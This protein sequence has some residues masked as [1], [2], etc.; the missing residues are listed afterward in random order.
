MK[1]SVGIIAL[2]VMLSASAQA[3]VGFGITGGV[4]F[5]NIGGA[6]VTTSPQSL[7]GF[8]GGIYLDLDIPFLLSIQPEVLY[9]MKG[10]KQSGTITIL[11]TSYSMSA[12]AN[13]NYLEIPVLIKYSFPVPVLKPSLFVGPSM[14]ILLSAKSKV[15]VTGQPTQESDIKSSTTSTDWG[16][17]VGASAN[18]LVVNVSAR[19]TLGLTS[20]DKQNGLKMYNRVFS[21]MIGVPL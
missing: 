5:A 9:S 21:L 18:I 14:G 12:T 19:Y 10:Y 11:S 15:D 3:Q 2:V 1:Q 13:L 8:T 20:L 7:T 16:L 17:V 6:D 4:N